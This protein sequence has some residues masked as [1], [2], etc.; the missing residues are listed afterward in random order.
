[1]PE[2][3]PNFLNLYKEFAELKEAP[4]ACSI[5]A[6]KYLCQKY[7]LDPGF[8]NCQLKRAKRYIK[9][10]TP[11]EPPAAGSDPAPADTAAPDERPPLPPTDGNGNAPTGTYHGG[12][13]PAPSP[14]TTPTGKEPT[15]DGSGQ[16]SGQ[17]RPARRKRY[18]S[19]RTP[20]HFQIYKEYISYISDESC[21]KTDA[22]EC[23]AQ[24]YK[25]TV[26]GVKYSISRAKYLHRISE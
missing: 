12:H 4:A 19:K 8:L 2:N 20:L 6:K 14:A 24:K 11:K 23:L 22:Y 7:G 3:A 15:T 13:T 1:M 18:N 16:R 9:Q 21:S 10:H 5:T 26:K 25:R 17:P